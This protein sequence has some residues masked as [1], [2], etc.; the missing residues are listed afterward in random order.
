[1]TSLGTEVEEKGRAKSLRSI[2]IS[3]AFTCFVFICAVFLSDELA[4]YVASGLTLAVKIIIPAVFPFLLLTDF[5]MRFIR[6]EKIGIF[7]K[8]FERL[9]NINGCALP[10]FICGLMCGFPVGAKLALALYENQKI[11]RDEC[12]RLMAFANNASPGYVICAVGLGMR[13]SAGDGVVLY[14]SM[15]ISSILCGMLFGLK[16]RK[17]DLSNEIS[18]QKYSFVDSTKESAIV[19]FNIA[20]FVTV[21]SMIAGLIQKAVSNEYFFAIIISLLEIGNAGIYLSDLCILSSEITLI[22]TSFSIS[23]SG[24]CVA[25]QVISLSD[26]RVRMPLKKYVFAKLVQGIISA[27]ITSIFCLIK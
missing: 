4:L 24:L 2:I 3:L 23:F 8:I 22:L 10:V 20:G 6:F 18:W 13:A 21:F 17:T 25:A 27:I 16:K 9:F 14:A 7:K 26:S 11:S 5:S 1:M 15:A 12:E 19:C